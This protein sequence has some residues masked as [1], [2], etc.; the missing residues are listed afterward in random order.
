M[1][2]MNTIDHEETVRRIRASN[3][4]CHIDILNMDAA[5]SDYEYNILKYELSCEQVNFARAASEGEGREKYANV[6]AEMFCNAAWHIQHGL[7]VEGFDLTPELKR[8]MCAISWMHNNQN[9]LLLTKKEELREALKMSTDIADALAL[10]CLDRYTDDDPA[11]TS[12]SN[13]G[14]R[15]QQLRYARM[16]G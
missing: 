9:R 8:Q 11:M 5:F 2:K 13:D 16:M 3:R 4:D 1:W 10:T 14:R 7:C 12:S 15:R 6:R